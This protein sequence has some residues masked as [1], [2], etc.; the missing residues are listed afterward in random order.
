MLLLGVFTLAGITFYIILNL[1]TNENIEETLES[2]ALRVIHSIQSNNQN[3]PIISSLDQTIVIEAIQPISESQTFS[4]TTILDDY[5]NEMIDCRKLTSVV[6]IKNQHYRIQVVVSQIEAE[7]LVQA[8]S[9]FMIGLFVF[10]VIVLFLLNRWLSASWWNPFY[11]TISQLHNF[12]IGQN[13]AIDFGKTNIREFKKLNSVLSEMIQRITADYQNMKEFT[14][15]ASHEIQTPLAIIRTKLET[16][17]QNETLSPNT[18]RQIQEAYNAVGR[19]SKLSEALLLISKIEN[20]QFVHIQEVDFSTLINE[21]TQFIEELL[22]LKNISINIQTEQPFIFQMNPNL[23]ETL[24]NNLLGNALKHSLK[25]GKI[26]ICIT[27]KQ[28]LFSNMG[29][30]LEVD[31]G[32]IFQRFV[33]HTP[34]GE[35]NGLGL[36]IVSEICKISQ[37]DVTY[38]Y[39]DGWHHFT[40]SKI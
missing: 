6:K 2:K 14:E 30:P 3:Q 34:N 19:L 10:I 23:A 21:R 29:E 8:I 33:K 36:A 17:L 31:S 28:I 15:N 26:N 22:G 12:K 40:I 35:S 11:Q 37:L 4:D 1:V 32:K 38:N 7:D 9:F 5:E 39:L 24:V 18:H 13:K 16:S 25:N 27:K 20:R